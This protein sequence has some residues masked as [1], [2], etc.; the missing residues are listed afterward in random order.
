MVAAGVWVVW[1][2]VWWMVGIRRGAKGVST[3]V[4][5]GAGYETLRSL[6]G[7]HT[8]RFLGAPKDSTLAGLAKVNLAHTLALPRAERSVET[9]MSWTG[10]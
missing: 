6:T 10:R 7:D 2:T 8:L 5:V 1:W 9:M 3:R 4:A